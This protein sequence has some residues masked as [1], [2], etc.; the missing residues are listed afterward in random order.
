MLKP[1]KITLELK[2]PLNS[3]SFGKKLVVTEFYVAMVAR[4]ALLRGP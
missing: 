4:V 2:G 3:P 1:Y